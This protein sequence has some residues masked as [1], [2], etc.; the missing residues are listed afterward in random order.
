MSAQ[1]LGLAGSVGL[2]RAIEATG[3]PENVLFVWATVQV[4][5]VWKFMMALALK[6]QRIQIW[7]CWMRLC[8]RR[9][10]VSFPAGA[11]CS[12]ALPEPGGAGV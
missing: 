9:L 5:A 4:G 12:A 6:Q 3:Q 8:F 7:R 11:A 10:I 2:L 1:L